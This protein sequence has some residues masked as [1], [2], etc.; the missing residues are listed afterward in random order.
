VLLARHPQLQTGSAWAGERLV[1]A[2]LLAKSF[3]HVCFERIL[4]FC[5]VTRGRVLF[6]TRR[7]TIP[8]SAYEPALSTAA[9]WGEGLPS[10]TR[11]SLEY[12]LCE[13]YIFHVARRLETRNKALCS[14][15]PQTAELVKSKNRKRVRRADAPGQ[16]ASEPKSTKFLVPPRD[17]GAQ[18]PMPGDQVRPESDF[19]EGA[20]RNHFPIVGIGASAGGLEAFTELLKSLPADTGLGFVLVQ[21]LDPEHESALAHL[22]TR[23]TSMPVREITDNLRVE[24]NHVYI[25]PPNTILGIAQGALKLSLRQQNRTPPRSIDTFFESLA[26]DQ[27]E[28]AIGVVLSG[29][30]SDGTLG[31]EA[32]KAEGGNHFRPGPF[33]PVRFHAAQRYCGRVRG[34]HS[35]TRRHCQ[36]TRSDC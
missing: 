18:A 25:I 28:R 4:C 31:L 6:D 26:K 8:S 10:G 14:F 33:G 21:H 16:K 36:R 23:D 7:G 3:H 2:A 30:A 1:P 34:L 20:D 32:I 35:Q 13:G 24:P 22:L 19:P 12:P 27:G 29:A 15:V 9:F 17:D 5:S 11:T